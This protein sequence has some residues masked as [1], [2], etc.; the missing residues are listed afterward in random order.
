VTPAAPAQSSEALA[1][2]SPREREVAALI[3]TGSKNREIAAELFLSEKTVEG[4]LTNIF[5]KCGVKSR[6][7]LAAHVAGLASGP[8]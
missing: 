8:V 2:L 4:H 6:A 3:A 1:E 5:A 7:A